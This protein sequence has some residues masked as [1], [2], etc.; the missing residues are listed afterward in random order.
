MY[1]RILAVMLA[2][3][4]LVLIASSCTKNK[5]EN[6]GNIEDVEIAVS[7]E[8]PSDASEYEKQANP[9]EGYSYKVVDFGPAMMS[10]EV[11]ESWRMTSYNLSTIRLD[12]PQ[13]DP[14]FPGT[15]MY[16]KCLYDYNAMPDDLDPISHMASEYAK[17]MSVYITGLPFAFDGTDACINS[18]KIADDV[19]TPK[20]VED[21][22]AAATKIT[23]N[24]HI[25]RKDTAS[26]I[27]F[28]GLDHVATYFRWNT[29]P[30]MLETVVPS[31]K[32]YDAKALLEYMM[33]TA[34]HKEQ[35]AGNFETREVGKTTFSL[36]KE[37]SALNQSGNVFLSKENLADTEGMSI[38]VFKV[39][40]DESFLTEQYFRDNYATK[41]PEILA[42]PSCADSYYITSSVDEYSGEKLLDEFKSYKG[43][44]TFSC[45]EDD[46]KAAK[47]TYGASS[48]WR[49]NCYLVK[50]GKGIYLVADIFPPQ[51]EELA[52]AIEKNVINTLTEN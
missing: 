37:F 1:K 35:S 14:V 7:D 27:S 31:E 34:T 11:P 3:L 5:A 38:G 28:N 50:R 49:M 8:K 10:L 44:V 45:I 41:L 16:I 33:S 25:I 40:E 21:S 12:A 6:F 22:S 17:P 19:T 46:Y 30:V 43:S 39:N 32:G 23:K 26:T 20:F 52:L 15:T 24:V 42:D 18:Y 51:D 2:L 13:E 47:L 36:P 4:S 9:I 48:A 29:F